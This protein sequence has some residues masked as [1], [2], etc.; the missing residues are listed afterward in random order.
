MG[1]LSGVGD[2]LLCGVSYREPRLGAARYH[3][4][5]EFGDDG[6]V[7]SW[8]GRAR[9]HRAGLDDVQGNQLNYL[10]TQRAGWLGFHR[11]EEYG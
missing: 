9:V 10:W 3:G 6:R 1:A 5:S 11:A 4:C 7:F 2:G 8:D